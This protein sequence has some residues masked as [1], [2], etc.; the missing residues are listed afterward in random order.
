VHNAFP[1]EKPNAYSEF[2]ATSVLSTSNLLLG[3]QEAKPL[4]DR[5]AWSNTFAGVLNLDEPRTDCPT[6][7]PEIPSDPNPLLSH[8]K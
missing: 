3:L 1:E 6:K 4:G 5:M 8:I 2:D 7:M